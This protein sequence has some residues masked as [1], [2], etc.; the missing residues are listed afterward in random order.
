[1]GKSAQ[2]S[3]PAQ[4]QRYRRPAHRSSAGWWIA[5]AAVVM[6][7]LVGWVG[8]R[9]DGTVSPTGIVGTA[10]GDTAPA[11]SVKDIAGQ[12]VTL[13]P[14]KPT[15]LYFAAA[16]CSTC[17]YGDTQLR[18]VYQ[19]YG[20]SVQLITVDVDPQVDTLAM[21][22]AFAKEYGGPWPEV[23]DVGERLTELYHV[24]ALDTSYL[25]NGQGVIVYT[26]QTPLTS[27]QWERRL[28]PLRTV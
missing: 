7:A 10:V 13:A 12:T 8:L 4:S 24:T 6:L 3:N 19:R 26:T 1:M 14:G 25:I 20:S 21:V 28:A 22:Q 15:I 18:P 17:A 27:A 9:G 11:F 5:G 16:Y 23:L 2:R